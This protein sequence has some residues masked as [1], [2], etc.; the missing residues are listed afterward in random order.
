MHQLPTEASPET[1]ARRRRAHRILTVLVPTSVAV[2]T[3][4]GFIAAMVLDPVRL[5]LL[6]G[7]GDWADT[8]SAQS[9]MFYTGIT[10]LCAGSFL[11]FA[12]GWHTTRALSTLGSHGLATTAIWTGGLALGFAG[13]WPFMIWTPPRSVDATGDAFSWFA[14]HA[15]WLL[16]AVLSMVMLVSAFLMVR[17]HYGVHSAVTKLRE[18]KEH[19]IVQPGTITRVEF[20]NIWIDGDPQFDVTVSYLGIDGPRE[21]TR[22]FATPLAKAPVPGGQVDVWYGPSAV[23]G[24]VFIELTERSSIH[25]VN[26]GYRPGSATPPRA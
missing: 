22:P 21:T 16:P 2:W 5:L 10:A 17:D 19:G 7:L 23:D 26:P 18:A 14:Y 9:S 8:M 12:I 13:A 20:T 1:I 15:P 4:V 6:D 3:L 24:D 25:L 11:N